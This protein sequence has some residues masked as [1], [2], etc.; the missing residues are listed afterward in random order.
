MDIG[1]DGRWLTYDELAE[2]RGIDRQSARRMANRSHWRRQKDNSGIV[3]VCVP[4]AHA[5]RRD[6]KR[7]MPAGKPVDMP[8]VPPVDVSA[9]IKPLQDAVDVL[10]VQLDRAEARAD[11]L[12]IELRQAQ[13]EAEEL[14]L[15]ISGR[16]A[17]GRLARLR[18]AWRGQ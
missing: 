12:G 13:S 16:R 17:L 14:R 4:L 1:E 18:A 6:R 5:A 15:D 10:R 11:A 8:A 9:V 2:A 7:D 3:R